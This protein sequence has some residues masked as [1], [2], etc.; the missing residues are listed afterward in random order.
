M[1]HRERQ[2][3]GSDEVS[4]QSGL[5]GLTGARPGYARRS[6]SRLL[7]DYLKLRRAQGFYSQQLGLTPAGRMAIRASGTNVALDI[8]GAMAIAQAEDPPDDDPPGQE[9]PLDDPPDEEPPVKEPGEPAPMK[10]A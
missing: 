3:V 10:S 2:S 4:E 7:G 1:R 9:P 5:C 8:V 6:T